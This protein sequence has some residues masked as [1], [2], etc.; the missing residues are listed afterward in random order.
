L[1]PWWGAWQPAVLALTAFGVMVFLFG[2][3]FA[4]ATF[5][6]VPVWVL[7]FFANRDLKLRECWRLAGAALMPGALLMI[8][9]IVLYDFGVVD[10]VGLG[11]IAAGHIVLGWIYLFIG[12]LFLPRA[13]ATKREGKN[14]FVEPS[15][16]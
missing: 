16:K 4:L 10:L 15:A 2:S 5:Y 3:W 12:P 8:V 11:F 7:V 1:A 6:A 14:P 13:G 9:G